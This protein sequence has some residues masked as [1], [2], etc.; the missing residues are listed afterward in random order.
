MKTKVS[1]KKR[2]KSLKKNKTIKNKN[3]NIKK[4]LKYAKKFE[5]M[6]YFVTSK[7]PTKDGAPFW[8][9]NSPPPSIAFIKKYGSCCAGLTNLM[10]RYVGLE[11]PGHVTGQKKHYFIGGTGAW[12]SYLN[13]TKRLHKID[14]S[15]SYPEGTL[16]IQDYNP[17][18]QGHV[19]IVFRSSKKN[20]LESE[21]IH[22]IRQSFK[23]KKYREVVIE[24]LKNYPDYKRFTHICYPKDWLVKN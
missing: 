17:V 15:K 13:L 20:L 6:K 11:V 5:G 19:A 10:R 8:I 16:L 9:S 12:F 14:F 24:I 18:D 3:S 7:P 1:K 2:K 22:N 21:I 4:A 23:K